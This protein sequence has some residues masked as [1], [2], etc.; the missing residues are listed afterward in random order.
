MNTNKI[1]ILDGGCGTLLEKLGYDVNVNNF[2][3]NIYRTF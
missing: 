2:L 3:I 1:L